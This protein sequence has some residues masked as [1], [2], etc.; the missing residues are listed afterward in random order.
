MWALRLDWSRRR[1]GPSPRPGSSAI[2]ALHAGVRLVL[3]LLVH[4]VDR[5]KGGDQIR[6]LPSVSQI[7]HQIRISSSVLYHSFWI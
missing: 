7:R 6:D 3:E 4:G 2:Q 5:P 1:N